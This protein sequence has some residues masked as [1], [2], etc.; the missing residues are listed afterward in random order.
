[1]GWLPTGR[2]LMCRRRRRPADLSRTR[3]S[4]RGQNRLYGN[5]TGEP[6]RDNDG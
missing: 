4:R 1:V 6:R 3:R 2:G 5:P